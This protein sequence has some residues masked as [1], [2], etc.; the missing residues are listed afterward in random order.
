MTK[1]NQGLVKRQQHTCRMHTAQYSR[2]QLYTATTSQALQ[3]QD[4]LHAHSNQGSLATHSTRALQQQLHVLEGC[5]DGDPSM[6]A[7]A[8]LQPNTKP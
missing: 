1:C 2:Q 7:T 8:T 3:V 5:A 6:A 4:M